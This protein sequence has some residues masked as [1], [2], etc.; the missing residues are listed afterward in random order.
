MIAPKPL[1]EEDRIKALN[2]YS[3]L[4][5]LPEKT[6]DDITMLAS[7]ICKTPIS[8]ISFVDENRHWFKSNI[9]LEGTTETP[10]NIGFC[11]HAILQNDV[12]IINDTYNDERFVDS[13]LV[14]D[15]PN[16]RFYAGAPL[17][18]SKGEVLGEICVIDKSPRELDESQIN[19]LKALSRQVMT[20]LELRKSEME[21][22][23][24]QNLL[25]RSNNELKNF[26][27]IISHDL[28]TPLRTITAYSQL[29]SRRYKGKIDEKSNEYL[30]SIN[31]GCNTMKTLIDDL[32]SHSEITNND[33][34]ISE[35]DLNTVMN[36]VIKNM[37]YLIKESNTKITYTELPVVSAKY[38][39]MF[40][41]FMNLISNAIKFK[42][43]DIDPIIK[44]EVNKQND[45][46]L[47]SFNDNG[48][49]IEQEN[50]GKLF[51]IFSR[52]H[53]KNEIDGNGIGLANCK[54]ILEFYNGNIWVESEFGK[55][56]IFY[57]T[58][59]VA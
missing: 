15:S 28:K 2:S 31:Q 54:K 21:L 22:I 58:L 40:Q 9:G 37:D 56:S 29:L 52:L 42:N 5:T 41:L 43:K 12:F 6:Y 13:P 25:Q 26:A 46:W 24:N 39:H 18:T 20:Q 34:I 59:P 55:G 16:I 33:D 35:L 30:D 51:K 7:Y 38:A 53:T 44:I 14:T 3:I 8:L 4:D 11:A 45:F 17:I 36:D 23:N 47:F 48:I 10:R 19:T 32:L 27:H 50:I 1:N 49:G 57:F